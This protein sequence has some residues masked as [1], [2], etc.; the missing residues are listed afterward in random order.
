M[1]ARESVVTIEDSQKEKAVTQTPVGSATDDSRDIRRTI[2][3]RI[4]VARNE[5]GLSQEALGDLIGVSRY[6]I[7]RLEGQNQDVSLEQAGKLADVLDLPE[8]T[9]LATRAL[10]EPAAQLEQ[11]TT[12]DACLEALLSAPGLDRLEIVVADE[13]DI[14]SML[15]KARLNLPPTVN[16]V[17]PTRAR[18]EQLRGP[19]VPKV[20]A[21]AVQNQITRI[22]EALAVGGRLRPTAATLGFKLNL[23]ESD[24]IRQSF[25]LVGSA[26][27]TIVRSGRQCR[28]F[29]RISTRYRYRCPETH[30][31]SNWSRIIS[32]N[33]GL[34]N[35]R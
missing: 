22:F 31:S 29:S 23:Y 30:P 35:N 21:W 19:A 12:R 18:Q 27:G 15:E 16:I 2:A 4:R 33:C 17:F 14:L 20:R 13:L 34:K 3:G 8:I 26:E 5:R 32:M 7:N 10:T 6:V 28:T 11:P 9:K 1:S 25:V 24:D